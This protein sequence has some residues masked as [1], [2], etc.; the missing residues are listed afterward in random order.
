MT[1]K[2]I[3]AH[4]KDNPIKLTLRPEII[5]YLKRMREQRKRMKNANYGK[6]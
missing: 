5:A 4:V 1:A 6:Y 2:E 3:K